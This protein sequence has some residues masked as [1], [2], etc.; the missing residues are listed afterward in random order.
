M[1]DA[2]APVHA[3]QTPREGAVHVLDEGGPSRP[4]TPTTQRSFSFAQAGGNGAEGFAT[5]GGGD[6]QFHDVLTGTPVPEAGRVGGPAG[7]PEDFGPVVRGGETHR[8]AYEP[9]AYEPRSGGPSAYRMIED[10]RSGGPARSPEDFGPAVRG[11][12]AE[13]GAA[14]LPAPVGGWD[15]PPL[16]EE[17]PALVAVLQEVTR[18]L[19]AGGSMGRAHSPANQPRA[20]GGGRRPATR[21]QCGAGTPTSHGHISAEAWGGRASGPQWAH[22][23]RGGAAV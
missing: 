3:T 21:L 23:P 11:G 17:G 1:L 6:P 10:Q 15:F 9:T 7:S 4:R 8:E 20:G 22:H 19:S 12:E 5:A 14:M 18:R 2:S 16:P 13:R